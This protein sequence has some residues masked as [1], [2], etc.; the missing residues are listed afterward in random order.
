VLGKA[1]M[2]QYGS[3]VNATLVQELRQPGTKIH[4]HLPHHGS[5]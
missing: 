1:A 3:S 5:V 4:H 2:A